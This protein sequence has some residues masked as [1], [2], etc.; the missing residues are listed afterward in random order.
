MAECNYFSNERGDQKMLV[1]MMLLF[2]FTVLVLVI[3]FIMYGNLPVPGT[4]ISADSSLLEE[5][6]SISDE[7]LGLQLI[8]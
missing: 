7:P 3:Q 6:Y 1:L 4:E 5:S 8:K 2:V